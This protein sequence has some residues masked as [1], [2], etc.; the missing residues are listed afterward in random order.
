MSLPYV[1][2]ANGTTLGGVPE[3]GDLF[4]MEH[5]VYEML[6]VGEPKVTPDGQTVYQVVYALRGNTDPDET[7]RGM[8]FPAWTK[9]PDK[10]YPVCAD[11]GEPTPCKER[12]VEKLATRAIATAERYST[13]GVCPSCQE[14]VATNQLAMHY[15]D[16][17]VIPFGPPLTFHW[18]SQC[19]AAVLDYDLHWARVMGRRPILSCPGV[20]MWH[21]DHYE[22][23]LGAE[24]AGA[25]AAHAG[26]VVCSCREASINTYGPL[27]LWQEIRQEDAPALRIRHDRPTKAPSDAAMA[28]GEA[29]PA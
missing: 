10:H 1:W 14:V 26:H 25:W 21:R 2:S 24:C 11:C 19:R 27:P 7:L 28:F 15:P 5:A 20:A 12:T 6:E 23:T 22:C 9:Y 13:E 4:P 29:P 8:V 17:V 3:V 16:N 18:R